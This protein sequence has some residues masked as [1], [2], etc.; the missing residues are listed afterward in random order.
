MAALTQ[1]LCFPL[2]QAKQYGLVQTLLGRVRRL[3]D[4]HSEDSAKSSYAERQAVNSVIQGTASDVIKFAMV[5]VDRK[6]AQEWK[7]TAGPAPRLLMQIHDELIYE[8]SAEPVCVERFTTLL[9]GAMTE[10]VRS[11]L[12]LSIPLVVNISSGQTWGSM[13]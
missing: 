7:A 9:R 10:E 12:K 1:R 2:S 6:L 8:V 5:N 11:A 13:T 4:I 3:P